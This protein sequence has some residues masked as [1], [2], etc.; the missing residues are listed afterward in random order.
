[1]DHAVPAPSVNDANGGVKARA[2]VREHRVRRFVDNGRHGI[3][4]RVIAENGLARSGAILTCTDSNACA[5]GACSTAARGLGPAGV[6]T[7]TT[8]AALHSS[9]IRLHERLRPARAAK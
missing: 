5:G 3:C 7:P 8:T 9:A 1:M 4:H 2:F 6:P